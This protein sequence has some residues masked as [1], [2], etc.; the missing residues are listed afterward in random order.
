MGNKL[1]KGVND[2]RAWCEQNDHSDLLAEWDYDNNG[3]LSPENVTYGSHKVFLGCALN[4]GV[5][6]RKTFIQELRVQGV[7]FVLV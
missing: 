5:D 4:V 3:D 7:V 2:L 6:I 1:Q